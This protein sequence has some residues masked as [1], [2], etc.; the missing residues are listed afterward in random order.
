MDCCLETLTIV[1]TYRLILVKSLAMGFSGN[2]NQSYNV[3]TKTDKIPGYGLLSGN[4][5]HSYNVPTNTCKIPGYG[6][7][8][9]H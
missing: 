8:W 3:L 5:N 9:K 4:I 7:F 2:I 6:F 1:I